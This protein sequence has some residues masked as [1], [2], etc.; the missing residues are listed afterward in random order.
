MNSTV[1]RTE[2]PVTIFQKQSDGPP[3]VRL[4][5]LN[6]IQIRAYRIHQRHGAIYGG[7]NL[8]EWLEAEHELEEELRGKPPKKAQL[9]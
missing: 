6:E 2:I 1:E 9:Q 4:P 8:D 7:Y 3:A 5:S